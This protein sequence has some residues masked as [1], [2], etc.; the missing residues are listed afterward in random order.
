MKS[1]SLR[2]PDIVL[3]CPFPE[4]QL[5]SGAQLPLQSPAPLR[6]PSLS[7]PP[8]LPQARRSSSRSSSTSALMSLSMTSSTGPAS[9]AAPSSKRVKTAYPPV[10]PIRPQPEYFR[11]V[12]FTPSADGSVCDPLQTYAFS[13]NESSNSEDDD[14]D[15]S[16]APE[17]DTPDS[18]VSPSSSTPQQSWTAKQD[19]LI[20]RAIDTHLNDPRIAPFPG[21]TP[22]PN[23][24]HRMAKYAVKTARAEQLDMPQSVSEIRKRI[25][26]LIAESNADSNTNE[27][28]PSPA[29]RSI[30]SGPIRYLT[31]RANSIS[32]AA[33]ASYFP[34]PLK[35][36]F[37]EHN[38]MLFPNHGK[39]KL[40]DLQPPI[41]PK[42][43]L[44]LSDEKA[45]SA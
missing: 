22:P 30:G 12:P 43:S 27:P 23:L 44:E 2:P 37:H 10:T 15:S 17:P 4:A 39:R 21:S 35:S 5:R 41:D 42:E 8:P 16:V 38:S 6:T 19:S 14:D 28:L 26:V 7:G 20:R 11:D 36:P 18:A 45:S 34:M 29:L 9:A 13:S 31:A 32:A 33:S 25:T 1:R 3:P 40:D 24:L